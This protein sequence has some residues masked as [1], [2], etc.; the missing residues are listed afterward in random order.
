MHD[1]AH[2]STGS[3]QRPIDAQSVQALVSD[4][5]RT[6]VEVGPGNVLAG[7]AVS[8][9]VTSLVTTSAF[10]EETGMTGVVLLVRKAASCVPREYDAFTTSLVVGVN[11]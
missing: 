8:L 6:F 7:L 10:G 1:V 2:L 3:C 5:V 4:G 11:L 9:A